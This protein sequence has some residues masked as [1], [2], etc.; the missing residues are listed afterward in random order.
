MDY[1]LDFCDVLIVPTSSFINSRKEINLKRT[2]TFKNG[3]SFTVCPI[4]ASNMDTV[5]T[6]SMMDSLLEYDAMVALHKHYDSDTLHFHF[7]GLSSPHGGYRRLLKSNLFYTV[8]ISEKEKE[9][10]KKLYAFEDNNPFLL[11]IDIANG[12][13]SEMQR[14]IEYYRN[15]YPMAIISAGNVVTPEGVEKLIKSGADLVKIGIGSGAQCTTRIKTGIGYPQFSS[16]LECKDIAHDNGCYIISDGGIRNPGDICKAFC[17]GADFVMLGTMLAGHDE[18]EIEFFSDDEGKEFGI[19]YGMSSHDAM[20]KYNSGTAP[21]R[22]SE[23][24]KSIVQRKGPVSHT[25]RDILG[26]LRS[27][28]TYIN[29]KNIEDFPKDIQFIRVLRQ[30]NH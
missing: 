18:S 28:G 10:F 13:I 30:V 24:K 11:N 16:I 29:A 7:G 6:L 14:T 4:I 15:E 1:K 27:C 22:T 25:M 3:H 19:I 5:G 9:N 2:F 17:A 8:G 21:Y 26:G 12:Y 20:K 23:G